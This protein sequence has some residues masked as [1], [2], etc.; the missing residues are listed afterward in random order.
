MENVFIILVAI[1]DVILCVVSWFMYKNVEEYKNRLDTYIRLN[2]E[3]N[4]L[5]KLRESRTQRQIFVFNPLGKRWELTEFE[6]IH[7]GDLFKII[8]DGVRYINK[9]NGDSIWVAN[10]A[11]YRGSSGDWE[12]KT[13]Y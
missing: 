5:I 7:D 6:N 8:Q 9:D 1:M 4:R 12:I 10:G 13:Y 11:P 3:R 2:E